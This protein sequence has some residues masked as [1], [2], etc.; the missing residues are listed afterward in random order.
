[1]RMSHRLAARRL[2]AGDSLF[3]AV[4]IMIPLGETRINDGGPE[5]TLPRNMAI[6]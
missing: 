4:F 2:R 5:P 1:M 6:L 3:E